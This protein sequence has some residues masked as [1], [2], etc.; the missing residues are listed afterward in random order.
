MTWTRTGFSQGQ[1]TEEHKLGRVI[2]RRIEKKSTVE[3]ADIL[4]VEEGFWDSSKSKI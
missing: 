4:V 1:G 2:L 3:L